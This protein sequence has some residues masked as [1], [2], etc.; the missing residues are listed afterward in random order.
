MNG[1]GV[2]AKS[3]VAAKNLRDRAVQLVDETAPAATFLTRSS[4]L[5]AGTV[6]IG[7][8]AT[9][10]LAIP[11]ILLPDA[12]LSWVDAWF[13]VSFTHHLPEKLRLYSH[14]YQAD[15]LAWTL[16]GYLANKVTAPLAANYLVKSAFFITS[17]LALFGTLRY[18]CSVRTC[19]F[20]TALAGSYSFFLHSIGAQYA[21]G[22]ANT[23]FLLA[24]YAATRA[25]RG[26]GSEVRAA[27]LAG[28]CYLAVLQAHLSFLLIAPLFAAYVIA[29]RLRSGRR[30]VKG[31]EAIA[32]SFLAGMFVAYLAVVAVYL[33]WSVPHAPMWASVLVFYAR[34]ENPL[35]WP[36]TLEWILV[37]FWLV[38]PTTVALWI[39]LGYVMALRGGWRGP[40]RLPDHYWFLLAM[41]GVLVSA[42]FLKAPVIM[43]PF[44]ASYLI[45]LTFL[46]LG[47]LVAPLVDQLSTRS[48]AYLLCLLFGLAATAYRLSNPAYAGNAVLIAIGCLAAAT[49]MLS[50]RRVQG[51][52]RP[53]AFA[54]LLIVA[55]AGINFATADY[56]TQ[57][58]NGYKHTAMATYYP[59][60]GPGSRWT[61]SRSEAFEGAIRAA[62]RL[63]PRLS[64]R[65]YYFL[66]DGNDPMGMFFRSI[67]SLHFAWQLGTLLGEGFNG[68]DE[69]TVK[70][71]MARRTPAGD[72]LIL[73]R[74]AHVPVSDTRL[75]RQWTEAFRTAG[76]D[77]YAH[78]F[79]VDGS[80]AGDW[81]H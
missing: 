52:W 37:S 21:D 27:F 23:Y 34:P 63:R 48:Y 71:L 19:A 16:P 39:G 65:T 49:A 77:Y 78:Y 18:S 46:A 70:A 79:I 50:A 62:E 76:T 40:L 55:F 8:L 43:V 17:L 41:Y 13:Y 53:T 31:F 58:R 20:V 35:I 14:L 2:A 60:P 56:S 66:Y 32:S 45:P 67:G 47:P 3:S 61:A 6:A 74:D 7:C 4:A 44:Y 57:I 81:A 12:D 11:E 69:G 1:R 51:S 10:L 38:M 24:I 36:D 59:Q 29:V 5:V 15:R 75:T 42:Y 22:A 73:T 28:I 25:A 64:G 26:E 30:D 80:R 9:V 54:A 68:V 72:L 33:R